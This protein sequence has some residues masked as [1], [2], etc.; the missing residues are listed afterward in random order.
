VD[1]GCADL[2]ELQAAL[3]DMR[4]ALTSGDLATLLAAQER[5]AAAG[6]PQPAADPSVDDRRS[7]RASL[8]RARATLTLCQS[9][10][11]ALLRIVEQCRTDSEGCLDYTRSGN[12]VA[13]PVASERE[14]SVSCRV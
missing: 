11:S 5:C 4:S 7:L 10:N 9:T 3:D 14:A 12:L 8:E 1:D 2:T 6:V 13:N